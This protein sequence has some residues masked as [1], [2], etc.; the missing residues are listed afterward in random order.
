MD[1]HFKIQ[2]IY[3][4]TIDQLLA[5]AKRRLYNDNEIELLQKSSILALEHSKNK[6]RYRDPKRSFMEHLIGTSAILMYSNLNIE[7]VVAGLL[8]SVKPIKSIYDLHNTVGEIVSNYFDTSIKPVKSIP[9]TQVD[10]I[11]WSVMCIQI[12]N[13]FDMHYAGE[14]SFTK[15]IV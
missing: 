4:K 15:S 2:G 13:N 1:P 7:T 8:H 11:K 10:P 12:A 6:F 5:L 9:Y 14:L 3:P